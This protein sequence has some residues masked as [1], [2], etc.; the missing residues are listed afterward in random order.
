[1]KK[2][3]IVNQWAS[4]LTKD[5]ANALAEKAHVVLIAGRISESGNPLNPSIEIRR[6]VQYERKGKFTR[7][8]TWIAGFIQ[9]IFL[10]IFRYRNTHLLLSS[11]PPINAFVPLFCKNQYSVQILDI[12]PDALLS[13]GQIN[14]KTWLY[15]F[16]VKHNKKY[17]QKASTVFTLTEGMAEVVAKYC[18]K[19]KI[20]VI[21]Q[22]PAFDSTEKIPI[23]E[24][25]FIKEY[26]LQNKFIVMYAGNIGIGHHVTVLAEAAV[27][28]RD[29]KDIMFVIIGEGWNKKAV[30]EVVK[31]NNISNCLVLPFQPADIFRH[32]LQ[33]SDLGVVSVSKEMADLMIPIKTY[34]LINNYI[35]LLAI[36]DGNSE[37]QKLIDTY[38]IGKYFSPGQI[39][40]ISNFIIEIKNNKDLINYYRNNLQT[41]AGLFSTENA[42]LY[43]ENIIV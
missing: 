27:I 40:E 29:H 20:K 16:W 3:V 8:F 18:E 11:N 35:P 39:N 26:C 7:A 19:S 38:G 22:W 14:R 5:I 12:Y 43:A 32:V 9:I 34:N 31:K 23:N 24:N 30:E 2:V 41:C 33:A 28:L 1:M 15:R 42:K 6:I 13:T 36:L 4:Y 37:L 25:R 17:F 10:I 21:H